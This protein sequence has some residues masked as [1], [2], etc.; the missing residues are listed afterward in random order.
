MLWSVSDFGGSF[1]SSRRFQTERQTFARS[2]SASC[3]RAQPHHEAMPRTSLGPRHGRVQPISHSVPGSC[4]SRADT[5]QPAWT[6]L[7]GL[8][9]YRGMPFNRLRFGRRKPIRARLRET[10][11]FRRTRCLPLGRRGYRQFQQCADLLLERPHQFQNAAAKPNRSGQAGKF[12]EEVSQSVPIRL[13]PGA[14]FAHFGLPG[15][16]PSL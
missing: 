13:Q 1:C 10:A 14:E 16:E 8:R 2:G 4:N 5:R 3:R 7:Q 11:P 9:E 6:A 12:Y 15:L